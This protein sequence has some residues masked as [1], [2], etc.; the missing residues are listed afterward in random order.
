M[1]LWRC[2]IR[3]ILLVVVPFSLVAGFRYC[4]FNNK[5]PLSRFYANLEVH[6]G[7]V[8]EEEH[9]RG[10]AHYLEHMVFLGTEKHSSNA[11]MKKIFTRLGMA[12]NADANAYTDFRSTVYTLSAPTRGK[13]KGVEEGG[14]AAMFGGQGPLSTAGAVQ[15]PSEEEEAE[16][17]A[18][19]DA[20]P[21][22]S[23]NVDLV[24]DLLHQMMFKARIEQTA[25]DSERGAILSEARDRN[26]I[27]TRVAMDYYSFFHGD[28]MLPTRFPIGLVELIKTFSAEEIRT[29]YEKHYNANNMCLYIAGDFD[30]AEVQSAIER[31][32]GGEK[33]VRGPSAK[34][35]TSTGAE[36]CLWEPRG[37]EITH[38]FAAIKPG[39]GGRV[40]VNSHDQ[41][42]DFSASFSVKEPYQS[43]KN[44]GD[45]RESLVDTIVGFTLDNRVRSL[46]LAESEPKFQGI[47]WSYTASRREGCSTNSFSVSSLPKFWRE[48]VVIGARE[49]KRLELYG[50][51]P[52]EL[53]Q[54]KTALVNSL[55]QQV[56]LK[57]SQS[58]SS[59]LSKVMGCVQDGD[60][61]MDPAEK[62]RVLSVLLEE[63]NLEEINK[64]AETLFK[65]VTEF[66]DTEKA[67]G[68]A[69]V[70]VPLE[71]DGAVPFDEEELKQQ[72]RSAV[73]DVEAPDEGVVPSELVPHEEV[74]ALAKEIGPTIV[75][76]DE[77]EETGV[78]RGELSNGM[79]FNY[80]RNTQRPNEI[81]IRCTAIGGR[82][83]ETRE[84][85]G[86]VLAGLACWL[87]GGF[88]GYKSETIGQFMTM[89]MLQH[90]ASCQNDALAFDMKIVTTVPG[91]LNRG[92]GVFRL[93]LTEPGYD[94]K[95]LERFKQRIERGHKSLAKSIERS[96]AA[97][98]FEGIM[99]E[100]DRWKVADLNPE[101][102]NK[103][104]IPS[105][106]S[107]VQ[108]SRCS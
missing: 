20:I 80:R 82:S 87:N 106:P 97:K 28:T 22:D 84:N 40:K 31:V 37:M 32:F 81:N 3:L 100:G 73:A 35:T 75:R 9:E 67:K 51:T 4:I 34:P 77:D 7:S 10:I 41:I 11:E 89:N 55:A 1:L 62:Q 72:L 71:W 45:L 65:P 53:H 46:K 91:N 102:T 14:G 48:A 43:T 36:P 12:F 61:L 93:L 95:S 49:A 108:K 78:V 15:E 47:S 17:V 19:D 24:L 92:L 63:V 18:G 88:G 2:A 60:Q 83:M 90:D 50:V 29:F 26:S 16:D 69:F 105:P 13:A 23:N 8:D 85:A 86:S 33:P 98:F 30:V 79:R 27:S 38:D 101:S 103:Y 58:S 5:K 57:D 44:V 39:S 54:A 70:S 52:G 21:D 42:Q 6:V 56:N 96:T 68:V 99:A 94:G 104:E 74:V 76:K 59:W 25:V 66:A 64:R 107:A